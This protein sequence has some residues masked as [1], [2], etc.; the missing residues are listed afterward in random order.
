MKI[1]RYYFDYA[2]S[3]P[4]DLEVEKVMRP[5][6][7]EKF[8]N[9]SS[10]HSFGQE[11]SAAVF[12]AR[13][14]IAQAL[15]CH[16]SEII[17]TGSATEANNLALR[18]VTKMVQQFLFGTGAVS[19][20]RRDSPTSCSDG[21]DGGRRPS[22]SEL[23]SFL[24]KTATPF[25]P[26]IIVSSIEHESVLETARDLGR[27]NVEVVYV[28]VS[29][30]GI[31]DI[32]KLKSALDERTVLVSVMYAN[33]EVGTIQPI[34]KISEI[35]RNFRN[36]RLASSV[37]RLVQKNR[38][39]N[40]LNA[41]H[42]PLFHVDAVQAFNY[43]EC[44]VDKLG[45][46][47]MTLSAQKIYGPKGIGLL[48][49]RQAS[50]VQHQEKYSKVI[51]RQSL[52]IS[53]MITGGGQEF[54]LRS[55]TENVPAIVGFSRA[56]EIASNS[57]EQWNKKHSNLQKYFFQQLKKMFFKQSSRYPVK[58]LQLDN[59]INY[60]EKWVNGSIEVGK[61]LPNNINFY[62]PGIKAQEMLMKLDL[63][64]FAVS[65]G[66]ACAART[67][68]PSHVIKALGYGDDRAK[69]SL[70]ITLGRPTKKSDI[71]KLTKVIYNLI[72]VPRNKR[73]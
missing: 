27:D 11:T 71:D 67:A 20:Q 15:G 56:V 47:L 66:S 48:Y 10:L 13:R 39:Y 24:T 1:K 41:N 12:S 30:S 4:I 73:G 31:V 65:S 45:V 59:W 51:S 52:V 29:K 19:L 9:P 40:T 21:S 14:I 23:R 54:G 37:E 42:Y 17:F 22:L 33:N 70:R 2:A 44:N 60:S 62:F 25:L 8:G 61:R 26:K 35:I 36:E 69:N 38:N 64:G 46:D 50:S 18:G 32:E 16:Y 6:W 53:P 5:F 63:A 28:P 49:V 72:V 58:K 3:T 43:L 68:S 7:S 34:S 55:G 57:R